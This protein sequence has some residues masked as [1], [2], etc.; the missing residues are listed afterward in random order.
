MNLDEIDAIKEKIAE[1]K[2]KEIEIQKSQEKIEDGIAQAIKLN[3]IEEMVKKKVELQRI[4][5]Q[6]EELEAY[7]LKNSAHLQA[8]ME[9]QQR[10]DDQSM[11]NM[12]RILYKAE[13]LEK[14][15]KRGDLD[16]QN[17]IMLA[18]A[19]EEGGDHAEKQR[20]RMV[21]EIIAKRQREK[22]QNILKSETY[23]RE[24]NEKR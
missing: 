17:Q 6:R 23:I 3:H 12:K 22:Q 14:A 10:R 2:F 9:E 5:A 15:L 4:V 20:K 13:N 16:K 19:L 8:V 21:D 1:F 7:E 11:E 24:L 18:H